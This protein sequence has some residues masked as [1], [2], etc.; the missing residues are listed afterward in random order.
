MIRAKHGSKKQQSY[1]YEKLGNLY[2]N[3]KKYITAS[4]YYDSVL[5]VATNKKNLRIRRVKRKHKNLAS[6]LKYETMLA[7]NDSILRIASMSKEAQKKYFTQYVTKLKKE[8]EE[9]AQQ[10]LNQAAFGAAFN[11]SSLQSTGGKKGKWYFYNAQLVALGKTEFQKI[12][13]NIPLK[14]NWRWSEK[15]IKKEIKN[16]S[17]Q[18]KQTFKKYDIDSYISLIPTNKK[19]IDSLKLYR[20]KALYELG[21][22]Y[23]EQFNN[24]TMAIKRLERLLQLQPQKEQL[25]PI[26]FHLYQIYNKLGNQKKAAIHKKIVISEYPESAFAQILLHPKNPIET[27]EEKPV[28]EI[29]KKYKKIYHLYAD[30]KYRE[31][32]KEIEKIIPTLGKSKLIPKFELLKAY[33]IGKFYDKGTFKRAMSFV[34]I[35]YPNTEE[36]K[37]AKEILNRIKEPNSKNKE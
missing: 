17:I 29:E 14:D 19:E 2:F 27:S 20:N 8:D 3:Q 33:A 30:K 16:D 23:K 35:T 28:T 24:P 13:G 9:R 15:S 12:W 34:A 10:Q 37:K 36:G 21:L 5:Q 22:I 32:V 7:K 18:T 25:L 11:G 31:V 1:T 6:L 4:N 26:H